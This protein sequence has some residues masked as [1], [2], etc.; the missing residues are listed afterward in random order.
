MAK[1]NPKTDTKQQ[2]ASNF[3]ALFGARQGE[4]LVSGGFKMLAHDR[5]TVRPQVR[6]TFPQ[7]EIDELRSSIRELRAQGGGIEGTGVLQALLV[8]PEGDRYRLI[9]GEK[10]YR[11]TREEGVPEV[12]CISVATV[13]EGM[14]RL[15]QLTEN[16]QR[17]DPAVMEEAAALRE[18]MTAQNLSLRDMARL[19]GKTLGYV[20]NRVDLLKMG[21]DV[22]TMVSQRSDTLKHAPIIDK[23]QDAVTR[24]E[25]IRA[26]VMDGI[27]VREVERRVAPPLTQS[28]AEINRD[29][30]AD[31]DG[32]KGGGFANGFNT[33]NGNSSAL[34]DPIMA[35]LQPAQTFI[36]EAA[37]L[38]STKKLSA[39]YRIKVKQH[40]SAIE[41]QI[42]QLHKVIE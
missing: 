19:L 12:P 4:R 24:A 23:I 41:Q 18:T 34:P 37:R 35:A 10:R 11:S 16:A 1:I 26:V 20:T 36:T 7:A 42:K 25:L 3:N 8:C 27:S 13:Q 14:I 30:T 28:A 2:A 17:T 5:I 40:L 32:R 22:Q 33:S 29:S 6:Q 15:L 39:E 38:L 21:E 9:M 31:G